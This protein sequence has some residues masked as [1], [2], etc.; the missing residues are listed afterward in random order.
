[1]AQPEQ[2]YM[3]KYYE[4]N[5]DKIKKQM[6]EKENCSFCN[7]QVNHQNMQRHKKSKLCLKNRDTKFHVE[8]NPQFMKM[9][10]GLESKIQELTA[11]ISV[12]S[13]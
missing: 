9:L 7:R 8:S 5:K 1:M 12:E 11:K 4:A 10:S 2:T 6:F 3:K 13:V